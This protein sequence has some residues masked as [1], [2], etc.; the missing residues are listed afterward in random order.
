[1]DVGSIGEEQ[2][3]VECLILIASE[4]EHKNTS[5]T[6]AKKFVPPQFFWQLECG[7]YDLRSPIIEWSVVE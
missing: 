3:I 2:T 6:S 7:I 1:M 4:A 5:S